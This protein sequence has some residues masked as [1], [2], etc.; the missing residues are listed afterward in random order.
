[1]LSNDKAVDLSDITPSDHE[2]AD[3]RMMLHLG[4]AVV[5]GQ[6]KAFLQTV[7][8]DAVLAVHLFTT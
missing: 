1:M 2:E 4:H 5:D 7:D 3:S 6:K 8:S